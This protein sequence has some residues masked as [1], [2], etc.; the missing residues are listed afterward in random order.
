MNSLPATN[1][2]EFAPLVCIDRIEETADAATFVFQTTDAAPLNF[3]A[4]QFVVFQVDVADET[5][6]RA[7]S[8]SSSP[9]HAEKVSIAVKRVVGGKVSNHLL[10][11]LQPGHM[12]RA[13][14]PAGEFNIIDRP[15]TE[16]ILLFSAG[17]G[18]T[19]CMAIARWLLESAPAASIEFIHSAYAGAEVIMADELD[20]LQREH[21]NFHLQRILETPARAEDF[22]GPITAELFEQLVPEISGRTIFT[23]GPAGYMNALQSFAEA[24]GFDMRYFHRESFSPAETAVA[25][26]AT[27]AAERYT[28]YA[29]NFGKQSE[30]HAQQTLLEALESA[31]LPII[32][33]CRS[34]VC[35]SCKCQVISGDTDSTSVATLSEAEVSAG[36][37]LACSSKARSDL[38]IAL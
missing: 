2:S 9:N 30:I 13:L 15:S 14:P 27:L 36:F 16:H 20:R 5:L 19:P 37:V 7:Y 34:G 6:H 8:L 22:T 21:P 18:I 35:G 3:K 17:C 33:A 28:L 31:G 10:D 12:L 38:V 4:G 1:P 11:H 32:G 23:C 24:R 25:N 26:D 29:P